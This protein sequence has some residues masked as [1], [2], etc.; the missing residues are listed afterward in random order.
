LV[1][2]ESGRTDESR[3][4]YQELIRL[5]SL[6]RV[7]EVIASRNDRLNRN[8]VEMN[9]FYNLCTDVGTAWT[10]T[11]EP[12]I[13][14]NSPWGAELR[15]QKAY[16]AQQESERLGRRQERAY[17]YAEEAGKAI[18]RTQT[19]GYRINKARDYEIDLIK[20]D[21]S[22]AVGSYKGNPVATGELARM[23]IDLFFERQTARQAL[24]RWKQ[25]ILEF[26]DLSIVGNVALCDRLL[27]LSGSFFCD[28]IRNP[29]LRGHIAYGKYKKI[30]YGDKLD[31]KR[32]SSLPEHEWR[33]Q[34]NTH[35]D[36]ALISESEYQTIKKILDQNTQYGYAIAKQKLTEN[37]PAS[38]SSILRC[39]LCGLRCL[40]TSTLKKGVRYRYYYCQGKKDFYCKSKS[41][42]EKQLVPQIIDLNFVLN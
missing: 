3:P 27:K 15:S 7:R 20:P 30:L 8:S 29:V 39:K 25:D 5:I 34:W 14:S 41:I 22:N 36:Q 10:Y 23:L 19:M 28:W 40:A 16:E 9:F 18:A 33:I 42:T 35:P 17:F 32:Y 21:Y 13:S 11:D 31:K 12:E 24:K 4:L 1:E 6:G 26:L 2:R 37:E 38:L